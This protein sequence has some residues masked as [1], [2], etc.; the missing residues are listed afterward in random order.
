MKRNRKYRRT[1]W[2]NLKGFRTGKWISL[3]DIHSLDLN[4]IVKI[5]DITMNMYLHS[6]SKKEIQTNSGPFQER[7]KAYLSRQITELK[8]N[9]EYTV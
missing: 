8:C 1:L 3:F 5:M 6:Q 7:N 9:K 2:S 4:N